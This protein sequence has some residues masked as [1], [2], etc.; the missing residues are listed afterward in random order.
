[1]VVASN[2]CA[3]FLV[4]VDVVIVLR[5]FQFYLVTTGADGGEVRTVAHFALAA[6]L[7]LLQA[8]LSA[9]FDVFRRI[10]LV[11]ALGSNLTIV[12]LELGLWLKYGAKGVIMQLP[13]AFVREFEV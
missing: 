7:F 5:P 6:R 2:I 13:S 4:L 10:L 1:M 11:A 12:H 8:G 3:H 9:F